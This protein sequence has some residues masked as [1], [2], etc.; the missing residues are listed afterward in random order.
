MRHPGAFWETRFY[1]FNVF[2]TQKE[3]EKLEYMHGNPVTRE[4]VGHP[5]DWPWSSWS[6][7]AKNG[8][9]LIV[10]DTM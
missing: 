4:L 10:I 7:Y 2:T 5:K 3:R 1:D 6:N 9:G 8:Q